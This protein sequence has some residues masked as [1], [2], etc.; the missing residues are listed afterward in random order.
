[1]K[2]GILAP[3]E[4]IIK[5][6]V[7][8]MRKYAALGNGLNAHT[9]FVIGD[10]NESQMNYNKIWS[11]KKENGSLHNVAGETWNSFHCVLLSK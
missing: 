11:F 10:C 3:T 8:G 6:L 1:M 4:G 9:H 2:P 5:K 7:D